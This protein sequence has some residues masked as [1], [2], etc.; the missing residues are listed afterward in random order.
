VGFFINTFPKSAVKV[1]LASA[2]VLVSLTARPLTNLVIK[3][4]S[5]LVLVSLTNLVVK[6]ASVLVSLT[7]RP[8]TNLVI[9]YASALVLRALGFVG[10]VADMDATIVVP[11]A[12]ALVRLVKGLWR[13]HIIFVVSEPLNPTVGAVS[14]CSYV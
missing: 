5:A 10:E 4:A 2:L 14:I 9:K 13:R 7:A 6:H 1:K 12:R 8:L 11:L 3:Y